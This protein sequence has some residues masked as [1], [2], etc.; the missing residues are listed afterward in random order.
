MKK[1]SV[2]LS[3]L[4]IV[5]VVLALVFSLRLPASNASTISITGKVKY[6]DLEGGF[7]GIV[8]DDGNKYDPNNLAAEYQTDGLSVKIQAQIL[9]DQAGSHQ[10]G[11]LIKIINIEV[12]TNQNC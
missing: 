3:V 6:I 5:A 1:V 11:T 12:V 9:K 4:L 2:I 10:W 7:F 8:G